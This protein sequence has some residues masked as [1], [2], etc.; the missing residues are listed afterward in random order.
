MQQ[1]EITDQK[2]LEVNLRDARPTVG[3]ITGRVVLKDDR[4]RGV[5]AAQVTGVALQSGFRRLRA[6]T[7]A[8]GRFEAD[9]GLS[10][11]IV[12]ATVKDQNLAGIVKIDA[13]DEQVIVPVR[14]TASAHG[15]LIDDMTGT[16][17]TDRQIDYGVHVTY[18]NGSFSNQFGGSVT[19][20]ARGE[21]TAVG[22][23]PG[24]EYVFDVVVSRGADGHAQSW[25]LVGSTKPSRPGL[26]EVGD[27]KLPVTVK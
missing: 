12:H 10:E 8:D 27:L 20:D 25:R 7:A 5:P 14:P 26:K 2:E 23:V 9:R 1:L 15:R 3:R 17:L 6:V 19:T 18:S 13:H 24:W 21:F 16:P 11:M 4:E 22:L